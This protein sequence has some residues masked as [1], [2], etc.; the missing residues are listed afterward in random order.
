[1]NDESTIE[2]VAAIVFEQGRYLIA[3]RKPGKSLAGQWEFP[4]GKIEPDES[5]TSALQRELREELGVDSEIGQFVAVSQHRY[6]HC[7]VSIQAYNTSLESHEFTLTDH[8]AVAW[9]ALGELQDYDLC[10]ADLPIVR[11]LQRS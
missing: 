11:A 6:Q 10:A 3:R 5:P 4:G 1:M 7:R 8:D 2:V 9:V